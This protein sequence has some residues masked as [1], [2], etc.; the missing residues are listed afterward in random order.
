MHV[1]ILSTHVYV[2]ETKIELKNVKEI[3]LYSKVTLK[4]ND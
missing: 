4:V 2:H 3:E 1:E